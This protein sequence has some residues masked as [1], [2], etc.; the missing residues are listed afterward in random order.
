MSRVLRLSSY[1]RA[2]AVPTA[3][4]SCVPE[5]RPTWP[6]IASKTL[7]ETAC[8]RRNWANR[9]RACFSARSPS[10]PDAEN[11]VALV[12][13]RRVATVSYTHLRAHETDSYLVCRLL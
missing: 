12:T 9:L 3:S 2:M 8:G 7:I 1:S 6:G 13:D 4:A 5:P 11:E 10:G